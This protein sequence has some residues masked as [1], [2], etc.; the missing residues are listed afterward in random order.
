MVFAAAVVPTPNTL[1]AIVRA[2]MADDIGQ[3]EDLVKA[4]RVVHG[5]TPEMMLALS[6]LGRGALSQ[7]KLDLAERYARETYG[8]GVAALKSRGM[9][10][11]P[12][13]PTAFGASIETLSQ[14][15]AGRGQ[16]TDAVAFL[17]EALAKYGR[18]SLQ[19]RLQ[20]NINLISLEGTPA[21]ELDTSEYLGA[22]GPTLGE[23]K[24]KVVLLFFWAHWCSDCKAQGPVIE[25]LV[26]KYAQQGFVVLAPTQRF[27]YV[28]N[29]ATASP[30]E[31]TRYIGEVRAQYYPWLAKIPVTLSERNHERYG[32]SST[33]TLALVDRQGIV[34]LYNPGLM[35][36]ARL[37]EA[38][39]KL[40]GQGS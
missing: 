38:I 2:T 10:D 22:R 5:T 20:K 37:D 16:R 32:V 26:H 31:E 23:L 15:A 13:F 18:T 36:E 8:L 11:E 39:A 3:A 27:G 24:G 6:W 34:R 14:I 1:V 17:N 7:E 33:P 21:P 29:G 19:K 4:Y 28:A 25:R 9:D 35:P 40:V 12:I 30:V